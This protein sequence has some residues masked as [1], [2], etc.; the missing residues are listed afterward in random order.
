MTTLKGKS[1]DKPMRA[2]SVQETC[3]DTGGIVFARHAIVA[4]RR[5][6]QIYGDGDFHSVTC[7]RAPWADRYADVGS[8]PASAAIEA[9]GWFECSGC[10]RRINDALPEQWEHEV[11]AGE[12]LCGQQ[13]LYAK[14]QPKH[15]I[16]D[17][18]TAVFCR[19]SCKVAH[20]A[21]E[22]E[23]KRRQER[24]IEAFKRIILRRFP[25][26]VIP[27]GPA[28]E[29]EPIW[30]RDHHAYASMANGRWRVKQV[31]VAFGFPGMKVGFASLEYYPQSHHS[32]A[33]RAPAFSCCNGD[34]EAFEAYAKGGAA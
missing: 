26:A 10:G 13:L 27:D 20:D 33:E 32:R 31:R 1:M 11:E 30:R 34:R 28:V 17:M 3:E 15:V 25:D 4:R 19:K 29:G 2:F 24:A 8:V 14:W 12:S 6:A 9:G 7:R 23:R 16:G 22:A 21:R 5:G 18:D